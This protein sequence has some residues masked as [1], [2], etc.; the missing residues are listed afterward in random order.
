[1]DGAGDV[2]AED[3]GPLRDEDAVVLHV[4][5]QGVD[6]HGRVFDDDLGGPRGGKGSRANAEGL[7]GGVEPGGGVGGGGHFGWVMEMFGEGIGKSV[8]GILELQEKRCR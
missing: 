7:R 1:V 5:V 4:A 2:A 8:D 6:G 3:G